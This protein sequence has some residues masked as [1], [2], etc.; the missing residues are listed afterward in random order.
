MS[1]P[2]N[3][4]SAELRTMEVEYCQE[5]RVEL[6]RVEREKKNGFRFIGET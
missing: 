4:E 6:R 2:Q 1:L 5:R 3:D